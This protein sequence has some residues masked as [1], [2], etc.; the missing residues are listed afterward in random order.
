MTSLLAGSGEMAWLMLSDF[1]SLAGGRRCNLNLGSRAFIIR[2]RDEWKYRL[3]FASDPSL[4][5]DLVI[6]I[7]ARRFGAG[8]P[9]SAILI[10]ADDRRDFCVATSA[11]QR[12]IPGDN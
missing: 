2:Q 10:I 5:F 3:L 9:H 8:G 1:A 12:R 6:H 4:L 11:F 7:F